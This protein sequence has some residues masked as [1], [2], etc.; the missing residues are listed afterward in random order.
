MRL[1]GPILFFSCYM[2]I[3][4]SAETLPHCFD[5]NKIATIVHE[6]KREFQQDF[7]ANGIK[8]AHLQWISQ[9]GLPLIMN[10]DFLGVE[11]PPNWQSLAN[12]IVQ[13]CFKEGNLCKKEDQKQ[14][15]E[16][17]QI[18]SP[19]ILLQLGSWFADNCK[20]LNEEVVKGWPSKKAKVIEL[21][22]RFKIK[23]QKDV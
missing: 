16:C 17:L 3:N 20:Q 11:P 19:T 22:N 6:L 1:T 2:M 7:C 12:E 9:S 23:S 18:K 5:E 14:F 10:K 13:D 21:I 4:A 8:P 15:V